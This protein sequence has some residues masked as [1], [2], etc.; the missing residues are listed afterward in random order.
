MIC[1]AEVDI[2]PV[3]PVVVRCLYSLLS[4]RLCLDYLW[5]RRPCL[6]PRFD[7]ILGYVTTNSLV[8]CENCLTS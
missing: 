8:C 6:F 5:Q 1:T 3:D 7:L 2:I 4:A